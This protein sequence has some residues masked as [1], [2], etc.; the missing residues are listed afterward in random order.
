VF[1][2]VNGFI[3][4]VLLELV[5]F[6]GGVAPSTIFGVLFHLLLLAMVRIKDMEAE[7]RGGYTGGVEG[8]RFFFLSYRGEDQA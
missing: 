8:W 3:R 7:G 2:A 4:T 5:V 6:R 1:P